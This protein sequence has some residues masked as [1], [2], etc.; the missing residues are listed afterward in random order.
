MANKKATKKKTAKKAT[1]RVTS[2]PFPEFPD[3]TTAKFWSYIR[4][5]L[6]SKWMRWPPRYKVLELARRKS[7]SANKRLKYEFQCAL[8][9]K[10]HPRDNVEVD[11]IEACGKLQCYEDLPGFVER[12]FVGV[13]KL[14]VLCIPCHREITQKAKE[15]K[16]DQGT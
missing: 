14:R 6:R 16:D 9:E 3:W 5:G 1:K 4:S 15:M 2:P 7:L 10:W 12:L 13:E 11:H 8:C